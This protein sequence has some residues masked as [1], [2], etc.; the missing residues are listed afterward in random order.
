MLVPLSCTS[1]SFSPLVRTVCPNEPTTFTCTVT[2]DLGTQN[3]IWKGD[4]SV[5][6]CSDQF[7][8]LTHFVTNDA[9][10]CGAASA[11]LE[12]RDG[13]N[14]TSVLTIVPTLEM[15]G[16]IIQCAFPLLTNIIGQGTLNV[17][18]KLYIGVTITCG[19]LPLHIVYHT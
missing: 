14:Y 16:S 10:D 13:N 2:D 6:N 5:F 9:D 12:P 3:S 18:S 7:I 4:N 15:D 1:G 8:A 19:H 11:Q 17:I